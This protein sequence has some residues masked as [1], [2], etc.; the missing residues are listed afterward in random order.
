MPAFVGRIEPVG[1]S[2]GTTPTF[3]EVYE[4]HFSF[5]W[6]TARRLGTP[7]A[8]LEDVTQEIFV[9]VH[10][11]LPEFAG[12]STLKTWLFSIT[13]RVVRRQ[14][15]AFLKKLPRGAPTEADTDIGSIAHPRDPGPL[16]RFAKQEAVRLL[17]TFLDSLD[18]EKREVFILAELEQMSVPE[19][20]TALHANVNTVYSRLRLARKAFATAVA[21]HRLREAGRFP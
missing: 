20:A 18:E 1:M 8:S 12:R 3:A 15:Q 21:R 9:V 16:E 4:D 5:V 11:K 6:R 2:P 10:R 14:R 13:R 7:D 19:I 17:A